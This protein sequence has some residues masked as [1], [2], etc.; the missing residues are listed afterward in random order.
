[1]NNNESRLVPDV[2]ETL[3]QPI[4]LLLLDVDGV[5]TDGRITYNDAGQELKSF[6]IHD[7]LG[8]KLLQRSGVQVGIVT[9]RSSAMVAR[10]ASELGIDILLQGREDKWVA[11]QSIQQQL[12]LLSSEIA[13]M[14]DDLPDL[15]AIRHVGLGVAPANAVALVRSHAKLVTRAAGGAGAVREACEFIL[16]AQ[17]KLIAAQ[18][19][20]LGQA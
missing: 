19:D 10:R 6:D 2:A 3:A 7:G 8:I 20:Y 17:G 9:G 1:M 16:A 12:G 11:V 15:S 14:G 5:M 18:H 4:K 13:Y